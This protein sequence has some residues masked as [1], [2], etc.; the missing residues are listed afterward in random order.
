[1]GAPSAYGAPCTTPQYELC[2]RLTAGREGQGAGRE[3]LRPGQGAGGEGLR[4][5]EDAGGQV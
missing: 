1:M 5:G 2:L 4:A 3:G